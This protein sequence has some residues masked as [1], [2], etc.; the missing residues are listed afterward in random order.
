MAGINDSLATGT[1]AKNRKTLRRIVLAVALF[2]L[3]AGVL[4]GPA[5]V[6]KIG[7]FWM[8]DKCLERDGCWDAKT[9]RCETEDRSRCAQEGDSP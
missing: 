1:A 6:R 5:F 7:G 8:E 4:I 3:I 9:G 2:W